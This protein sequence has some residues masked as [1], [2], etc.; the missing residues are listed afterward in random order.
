[1]TVVSMH[2]AK[3]ALSQLVSRAAQG[4]TIYIGAYGQAQAKIVPIDYEEKQPKKIGLLAGRL[5]VPDDFDEP[6]PEEVLA[7]FEG[8]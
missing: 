6:L 4:E 5:V 3:S 8:S 1:M 2:Q 7:G